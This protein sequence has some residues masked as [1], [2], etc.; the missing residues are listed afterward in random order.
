MS[1]PLFQPYCAIAYTTFSYSMAWE[2]YFVETRITFV[3]P[4]FNRV[5]DSAYSF[6]IS[7]FGVDYSFFGFHLKSIVLFTPPFSITIIAFN[8]SAV[9]KFAY[10]FTIATIQNRTILNGFPINSAYALTGIT[11]SIMYSFFG[12]H[13]N[14]LSLLHFNQ[15][16]PL[17]FSHLTTLP[18]LR[19]SYV[20]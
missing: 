15:P 11:L 3:A 6:T 14:Q 18:P 9:F 7:T 1:S 17:H 5:V 2:S 19:V 12:F 10:Y 16:S 8:Y 4:F 13:V 20:Q